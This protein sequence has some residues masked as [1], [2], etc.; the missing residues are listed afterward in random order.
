[1]R[2]ILSA[3]TAM[4]MSVSCLQL[5]PVGAV[6][7]NLVD[8]H[9]TGE[10]Y[11]S[12]EIFVYKTGAKERIINMNSRTSLP[13]SFD[14]ST[15]PA[16][17]SYFPPIGNQGELGS[18]VSWATTYYQFTYEVNKLRGVHIDKTAD[19]WK[20]DVY[21]PAWTYNYTNN[22]Q[23]IGTTVGDA[24]AVLKNQGAMKWCDFEYNESADQ[25]SYAWPSDQEKMIDALNYRA[26]SSYID[27]PSQSSNFN[28]NA[29]KH[30]IA[31]EHKVATVSTNVTGWTLS[32]T[33][34]GENIIVRGSRGTGLNSHRMALVGY[35]DTISVIVNG[36]TMQ[37]AFKLANSWGK[38]EWEDGNDGY[39]W[40]SYDAL[41]NESAHGT[42]WQTNVLYGKYQR[43][44]VFSLASGGTNRFY[45]IDAQ[46]CDV[47]FVGWIRIL[48]DDLWHLD[49]Y[50]SEGASASAITENYK[51]GNRDPELSPV[52]TTSA[53]CIA[54]DYFAPDLN[55]N[56]NNYLN[57][58]FSVR[59]TGNAAYD[60][61]AN[62][63]ILD[64]LGNIVDINTYSN[65]PM[66][67]GAFTS[68][69]SIELAKG[70]VTAYDNA[71]I[72]SADS[73]LVLNHLVENVE[74]SNLQL[75]LAD[76]N[77]D[78][79]VNIN[80][81][82]AMNQHIS[83]LSGQSYQITDYIEEWGYSLA[84]VIEEE[85]NTTIEEYVAEN[86]AELSA[87]NVIPKELRGDVYAY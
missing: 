22:S 24:Y 15:N 21:S 59:I 82:I 43:W 34:T 68:T 10:K 71:Q 80:D 58:N 65:L 50:A 61:Y 19:N 4:L 13:S 44:P 72:T 83:S 38:E 14:I 64:N 28:I 81:V 32:T 87:M 45:Y 33:N 37:G 1:M 78:G 18:C 27:I 2:K 12:H 84:D 48:S 17:A 40:V 11:E 9:A 63:R 75:F 30:L 74:F 25:Y 8:G 26:T 86:Y 77:S 67:N 46:E 56:L 85:Y 39:I 57:S 73:E 29:I 35:D 53:H 23:N 51:W 69:H 36:V 41:R 62:S 70:R 76:Y 52:S 60:T 31:V 7:E 5:F 55:P 49:L 3:I 47:N 66:I 54:F 16:T 6:G 20:R 79:T 42:E